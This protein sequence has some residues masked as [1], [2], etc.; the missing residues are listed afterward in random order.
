MRV[1]DRIAIV[2]G[3][4]RGIGRACAVRLAAEGAHIVAADIKPDSAEQAA[5]ENR[6]MGR[7]AIAVQAD[8]SSAEQ[9]QMLVERAVAEFGRLDIQVNN[10]G[11]IGP[12][13]SETLPES[14][15]DRVTDVN[16]KGVFLSSQAA[17]RQM[18]AQGQG[19]IVSIASIAAWA[20]FP[21]RASYNAAKAGVVALTQSLAV[22]WATRGVRVNAVGPGYVNTDIIRQGLERKVLTVEDV[23]R[24]TPMRRLAEPDDIARAVTFLAS[25]DA[26]YITGQTLYVDGGWTAYGLW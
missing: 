20:G 10:A 2:T 19:A 12:G 23:I 17:G 5:E 13:P 15:W 26:A 14:E 24:R 16:L 3:A 25:D 21:G 11:V 6:E 8:V 22:E 4:G 1:E 9:C 7:R 18:L